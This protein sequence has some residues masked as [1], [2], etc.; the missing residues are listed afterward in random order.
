M[1]GLRTSLAIVLPFPDPGEDSPSAARGTRWLVPAG[2]VIG[3]VY[4]ALYR[5]AWRFFGETEGIRL[6]PALAVWL[7]DVSLCG[8]VLILG[9]ARVAQ[10]V[11]TR[12]APPEPA[13]IAVVSVGTV[14]F[15]VLCTLKL[16]LW[17]AIPQGVS[18][19]PGIWGSAMNFAY[20][21]A[22]YRP[23]ILAPIWGRWGVLLAAGLGR[24]APHSDALVRALMSR[25]SSFRV[26]AWFVP[27]A[28]LTAI[29]CG[30]NARWM[31]GAVIALGVMGLTYLY[32]VAAAYRLTGQSRDTLRA[33][34]FVAELTFLILYTGFSVRIYTG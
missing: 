16:M 21:H 26:L 4:A 13:A 23:L 6:L 9:A 14:V 27:I 33:A 24:P 22:L 17:I 3:L 5:A 1:D 32:G 29:Y 25:Q 2:L 8:S 30:Y 20:P 31:Y 34:G 11:S 7:L 19:W 10:R 18:T 12:A 15:V 28:V